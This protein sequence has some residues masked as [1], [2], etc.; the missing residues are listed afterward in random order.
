MKLTAL[1]I[2]DLAILTTRLYYSESVELGVLADTQKPCD[3]VANLSRKLIKINPY[4]STAIRY[5][6]HSIQKGAK[7]V[8]EDLVG[9][10]FEQDSL[11]L[12]EVNELKDQFM[13]E[14]CRKILVINP[15]DANT[16]FLL[17][18]LI[19][20][21]VPAEADDFKGTRLEGA[22]CEINDSIECASV[23]LR[24]LLSLYSHTT[25]ALYGD[26]YDVLLICLQHKRVA[27][28][29]EDLK[30]TS[31]EGENLKEINRELLVKELA[32]KKLDL[33]AFET[34]SNGLARYRVIL[35]ESGPTSY[36]GNRSV[37]VS[38][39]TL[40]PAEI[41]IVVDRHIQQ[42]LEVE[43]VRQDRLFSLSYDLSEAADHFLKN[44]T[45]PI[46]PKLLV[47]TQWEKEPPAL[48]NRYEFIAEYC[49]LAL[50]C[51]PKNVCALYTLGLCILKGI[52]TTPR[53]FYRSTFEKRPSEE[54]KPGE[55]ASVLYGRMRALDKKTKD[56][57]LKFLPRY[58]LPRYSFETMREE[59]IEPERK[60]VITRRAP[61]S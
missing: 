59:Q 39:K 55:L 7:I 36:D 60:K 34:L 25:D 18:Y 10:S 50:K 29:I 19:S 53:D 1:E 2:K 27:L 12:M 5:L 58:S 51:Y 56:D 45:V 44:P 31:F 61:K 43:Y 23:L 48:V 22:E 4:C 57:A 24:K 8:E 35:G 16:L 40:S 15:R 17:A 49:R 54:G 38:N 30:G 42:Y 6:V 21:G 26:A 37:F 47:G 41:E 3:R 14:L 13:A 9:T 32:A 33:K 46:T 28:E 20:Q 52:P 11:A